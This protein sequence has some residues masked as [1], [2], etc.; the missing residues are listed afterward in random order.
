MNVTDQ[1]GRSLQ[2]SGN[3]QRI[4]SLAP[5]NTEIIYALKAG[6]LL[7]GVTEYCDYPPEAKLK[8]KVGGYSTVDI[9]RINGIKPD[10]ILAGMIHLKEVLPQLENLNYNTLVLEANSTDELFQAIKLCG[11]CTGRQSTA[12]LLA[13]SLQKRAQAVTVKTSLLSRNRRPRV[14]YLHE[15]HTWKTFGA[16][17]IGDTLT[18]LAGGYNVGRDFGDYYPYP[19]IEDIVRSN[20]DIIIAETGYGQNPEEPLQVIHSEERLSGIKARVENRIYGIDSDL[21]SRAGPRLVEG[22]EQLARIM[23]PEISWD[24]D[25]DA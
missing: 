10:L 15:L 14:Y 9:Q 13:A 7:C 19:T 18:E 16:K 3:I 8:K 4:V 5:S 23:H 11:I 21:I 12:D 22:L 2:L 1:A 25:V 17:T 6:D 20:P 24:V